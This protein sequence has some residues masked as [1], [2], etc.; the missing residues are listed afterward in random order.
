MLTGRRD[1][2]AGVSMEEFGG[3]DSEERLLPFFGYW[4]AWGDA[5][6]GALSHSEVRRA[7]VLVAALDLRL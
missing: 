3:R 2:W 6:S 1:D 7:G 5:P 4:P